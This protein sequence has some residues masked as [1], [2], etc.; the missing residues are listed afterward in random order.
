MRASWF[1]PADGTNQSTALKEMI[2]AAPLGPCEFIFPYSSTGFGIESA[3]V[4][5]DAGG[6]ARLSWK[7][8]GDGGKGKLITTAAVSVFESYD[9]VNASPAHSTYDLTFEN[10]ELDGNAA[11]TNGIHLH[12]ASSVLVRDCDIHEFVTLP[13]ALTNVTGLLVENPYF[14]G[15]GTDP[16]TSIIEARK[17]VDSYWK[18]HSTYGY[19][20]TVQS[21]VG[22]VAEEQFISTS[23]TLDA[24]ARRKLLTNGSYSLGAGAAAQDVFLDIRATLTTVDDT[25]VALWSMTLADNTAYVIEASVLAQQEDGADRAAFQ[26]KTAVFRT[27]AGVATMQGIVTN[28]AAAIADTGVAWDCIFDTSTNDVRLLVTGDAANDVHW[29][30][31]V[32]YM[33]IVETV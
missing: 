4:I 27:A 2:T 22:D 8:R 20:I 12:G 17:D 3:L 6:T 32:K 5:P 33:M 28:L 31:T 7:F 11:G 10:L 19:P 30:A 24:Y 26:I 18:V 9:V 25:P 1:A 15:N 14:W 23:G 21:A 29:L 13:L 16:I